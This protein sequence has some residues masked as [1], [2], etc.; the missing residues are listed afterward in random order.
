[1]FGFENKKF[2]V[3]IEF[4]DARLSEVEVTMQRELQ[5]TGIDV[6]REGYNHEVRRHWKIVTDASV[7]QNINYRE[8]DA[9]GGELVSPVL[10]GQAGLD[11]LETVLKALNTHP[12]VTIKVTCGLHLH[13][14]WSNCTTTQIKNIVRRYAAFEN[15]F[16]SMM[17][18]SRRNS[19]WCAN[20]SQNRSFL[21]A[22]E[23]FTGS[24]R[25]MANCGG[26]D[27]YRKVN[28]VPL[29]TY[30]SIEFRQHS[31]TTDFTKIKNW[32]LLMSDFCDASQNAPATTFD[33]S[34]Y[35]RRDSRLFGEV[36]ELFEARG[37]TV[38]KSGR[39]SSL[40]F[41]FKNEQGNVLAVKTIAQMKAM[42]QR[43]RVLGPSFS[44]FYARMFGVS[45]D[46]WLRGVRDDVAAYVH[47]RV[48]HF[49][50]LAQLAAA[51]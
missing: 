47:S 13:L 34:T 5:G 2:G 49:D 33:F 12:D 44:D 38:E 19:R 17:P 25:E 39:G 7:S 43:K 24:L 3:E 23:S 30:G 51:A 36:R 31:G 32:A 29:R 42:Y 16:D 48:N 6:H 8:R 1:M 18:P 22:V 10:Q 21:T 4:A 35:R 41:A 20:I 45:S 28:L 27:R 14:S 46:A 26:S 50:P 9:N 37:W 15:N 40:A 11:E